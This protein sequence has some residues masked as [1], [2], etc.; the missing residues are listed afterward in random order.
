MLFSGLFFLFV[1]LPL[2]FLFY[3]LNKSNRGRNYV[4]LIASLLFYAFGGIK[5]LILLLFLSLT[6]WISAR[7]IAKMDSDERSSHGEDNA[8]QAHS[9]T[10][11]YILVFTVTLFVLALGI[12]KYTGFFMGSLWALFGMDWAIRIALPTGISFYIFKLI[13][14]LVDVYR[15]KIEPEENFLRFLL[16]VCIFHQIMQG[17]IVRYS[18]MQKEFHHRI[19]SLQGLSNG[20]Y[21]FCIGLAKKAILA[22][23]L[24]TMANTF[25]PL[26]GTLSDVPTAGIWVGSICYTLQIYLD[27][28]AYTDMA[29]AL[30]E[31]IGFHYPE[32][33]NYPYLSASVKEFWRRWHMTL[34]F[35]F[36]DYVY[37]PL[38]GS[39]KGEKCTRL[40]LLAVWLLT[41][42]WHGASWNF[43]LWGLYFFAFILLENYLIRKEVVIPS[44]IRHIYLLFVINLSW[45]I[46]RFPSF[47]NLGRALLGF[48]GIKS[49]GFSN[50]MVT[51]NLQ[52]NFLFLIL[53]ILSC[54]PV[55]LWMSRLLQVVMQE[56]KIPMAYFYAGKTILATLLFLLSVFALAGN[57]YQPFL[58][59]QF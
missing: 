18:E 29:I 10:G 44:A 49:G 26:G 12:F 39:R 42:L 15:R 6:G 56:K 51:L 8:Q 30:G 55:F 25:L 19:F 21:R 23:H 13:S 35:F 38:G 20:I 17:P 3:F 2:F 5:Y 59:N 48:F 11:K 7:W 57:N 47:H 14:Y 22:D 1:F 16:Y 58:Y 28:S 4:L 46:F 40:N 31:M 37:F 53:A 50:A 45:I 24:G 9:Q 34:S 54:T 32:N 36:R 52:N 27:F 41:G 33:F 43:I